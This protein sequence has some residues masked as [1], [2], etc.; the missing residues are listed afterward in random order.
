MQQDTQELLDQVV[1]GMVNVATLVRQDTA[2]ALQ[3]SDYI[4]AIRHYV[5]VRNA[6]ETIK[7]A[8]K[9][10]DEIEDNLS[11]QQIPD[12]MRARE[13]KSVKLE[14]IGTVYLSNRVSASML[15]KDAGFKW[16]RDNKHDGLIT[17]TVNASTLA[18]FA[19]DLI[20]QGFELPDDIFKVSTSTFTAVKK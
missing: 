4:D 1:K 15:D 8:R 14:G 2:S 18:A 11:K 9:A 20:E 7:T 10:L 16:L 3:A 13:V 19:K 5:A 6:T 17:E 12:L